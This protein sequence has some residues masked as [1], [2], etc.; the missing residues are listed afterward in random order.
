MYISLMKYS[1]REQSWA[2]VWINPLLQTQESQ[3]NES[4]WSQKRTILAKTLGSP[5][6]EVQQLIL[7]T[8]ITVM[9]ASANL[10]TES[11]LL[12]VECLKIAV[13]LGIEFKNIMLAG[14]DHA[15]EIFRGIL[16]RDVFN[17]WTFHENS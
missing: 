14:T 10:C 6:K 11:W 1:P 3:N 8:I 9:N 17:S 13:E 16:P 4:N 5:D 15:N 7:S 12:I 2:S